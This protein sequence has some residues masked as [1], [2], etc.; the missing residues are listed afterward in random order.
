MHEDE[1][2]SLASDIGSSRR[3]H[4]NVRRTQNGRVV[5][6]VPHYQGLVTCLGG[7]G[8]YLDLF[9]W[10]EFG[11]PVRNPQTAGESRYHRRP[12]AGQDSGR[13]AQ[14]AKGFDRFA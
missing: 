5:Y 13:N 4:G 7:S 11:I 1:V 6:A 12:V 14:A 10:R 8:A 2:G 9:A 3:S